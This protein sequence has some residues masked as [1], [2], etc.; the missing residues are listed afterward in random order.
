MEPKELNG[1]L[2]TLLVIC[3]P[4]KQQ[5]RFIRRT[6]AK[7]CSIQKGQLLFCGD[8]NTP[9]DP[10]KEQS[11]SPARKTGPKQ[12]LLQEDLHDPWRYHHTREKNYTFFSHNTYSRIDCFLTDKNILQKVVKAQIYNISW[13]DHA[14]ISLEISEGRTGKNVS[15]W[16]N[17]TYVL[18][19]P[20]YVSELKTQLE[21]FFSFHAGSSSSVF[22]LWGTH[23]AFSRGILMQLASRERKKRILHISSLLAYITQLESHHKKSPQNSTL[24]QLTQ[25]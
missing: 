10:I 8:F 20:G 13:S 18:S 19:H 24:L 4:N 2:Y 6:L 12:F 7:P 21:E 11:R 9:M 1:A 22:N 14:P 25:L 3:I 5:I 23:K 17:N 16:R 15:L